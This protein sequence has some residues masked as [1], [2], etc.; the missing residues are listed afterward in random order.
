MEILP[1]NVLLASWINAI[2]GG[3]TGF[4]DLYQVLGTFDRLGALPA[5]EAMGLAHAFFVGHQ[6]LLQVGVE[7]WL[8]VDDGIWEPSSLRAPEMHT[9]SLKEAARLLTTS[10]DEAL[11]LIAPIESASDRGAPIRAN[12]RQTLS[13][14]LGRAKRVLPPT[15]WQNSALIERSLTVLVVSAVA[16]MDNGGAVTANEINLRNGEINRLRVAAR[17]ALILGTEAWCARPIP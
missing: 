13:D 9:H 14:V 17:E 4:D 12:I 16:T 7:T 15:V 8:S 11:E 3:R 10:I 2:R 1:R 5:H 6:E